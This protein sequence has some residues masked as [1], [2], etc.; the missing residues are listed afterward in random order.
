MGTR[1]DDA[2]GRP[3]TAP[4]DQC[5]ELLGVDLATIQKVAAGVEP[6]IRADSSKV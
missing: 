2:L 6:C 4:L 5:A 3:I 1:H